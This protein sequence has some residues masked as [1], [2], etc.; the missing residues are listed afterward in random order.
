MTAAFPSSRDEVRTLQ[1]ER[2]RAI[3]ARAWDVPFFR[4]K[5][6]GA[7]LAPDDVKSIEDLPKVPRTVKAEL[8]ESE[9]AYPPWGDY[10]AATG[11]V[12]VGTSTGTSGEP[13]V[14]LWTRH[15]L[16]VECDAAARM[17]SR[18]GMRP[19]TVVAHAHPLGLYGGGFL[20]S[21]VLE[22]FGCLVIALGTPPEDEAGI[23]RM[24]RFLAR[25]R[26]HVYQLFPPAALRLW[27]AAIRMGL[28][29]KADLNLRFPKEH[30][31]AQYA[32]ASAGIECL[33]YLGSACSRFDGAHVAEDLCIVEV[34]DPSTGEPVA[35][36]RRGHLVC[37]SIAKDNFLL[38]YDLEDV[39]RMTTEE[40]GC[41]EPTARVYWEG[42]AS[43][44]V[45]AGE[46][47]VLPIDVWTVLGDVEAVRRPSVEFQIVRGDPAHLR[48]RVEAGEG[49]EPSAALRV[50]L[51]AGLAGVFA[52]PVTVELL[53]RGSLPRPEFKPIRVV[54]R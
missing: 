41:G 48:V 51:E 30:P 6:Q 44:I 42:R 49:V 1:D 4:R 54:D 37:T 7:G 21:E 25:V 27:E 46:R 31:Q 39:V 15:D 29:P 20:Q 34:V 22:R 3:V 45:R 33:A 18:L 47:D 16:D 11:A 10:R 35:D 26:P 5:L 8:R 9:A 38:R 17:F 52:V 13:T 36:G 40:C 32:S 12:R 14:V 50:E 23:E 28:D 53:P 19:G 43:D 24:V 2:L